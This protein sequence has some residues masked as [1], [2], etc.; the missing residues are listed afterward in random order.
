[1]NMKLK[2]LAILVFIMPLKSIAQLD[3][4]SLLGNLAENLPQAGMENDNDPNIG[5]KGIDQ[6]N[7]PREEIDFKDSEYGFT[8]GKTFNNQPKSKFKTEPLEYFGYDFFYEQPSTFAQFDNAPIPP[9][10]VIG[11]NDFIKIILFGNVNKKY[12][13]TVNRDGDIFVP[14]IGPLSVAGLSFDDLKVVI[15]QAIGTQLIGTQVNIT[16]GS[17]RAIDIFI[18]GSASNPGMFSI[19]ALSTITNAIIKSGGVDIAGSLRD[20]KIKRNGKIVK[21]VDFY[22][23][24]LNG[25][26][27]NDTRLMQ[28]D[29]IFIEPLGKTAAINGEVNRPGI[30]ELKSGETLDDLLRFAG[31]LKPK[32][33]LSD[34]DIM[35]IDSDQNSFNLISLNL[36]NQRPSSINIQNGDVISIYSVPDNLKSALLIQ[37]HSQQPGFYAW[38]QGMR[39]N[40]LFNSPED[41]LEMTDLNYVL[42]KRKESN[43]KSFNF[44]QV[45]LEEVFAD[46]DSSKNILLAD[47]DEIFL[48]PSM[49]TPETITTRMIQ[50]DYQLDQETN[51]MVMDDE[52]SS[53]TYLRKSLMEETIDLNNDQKS[54]NQFNNQNEDYNSLD[55]RRYYEYS[56]FDYC[57]LPEDMAIMVAEQSGFR[58]KKSIPIED[59]E[60]LNSPQD[61]IKFQQSLE[62]ERVK[63]KDNSEETIS[64]KLTEL[65][66]QQIL[67]PII[68][69][70]KR[71]DSNDSLNLVSVFGNVH[72]PGSYP[73]TDNMILSDVIKAAGGLKNGTYSSEVELSRRNNIGKKYSTSNTYTNLQQASRVKLEPMDTVNLKQLSSGLKTVEILG[74]VYFPGVYPISENQT[75]SEL[76]KRAGGLTEY[77]SP[78]SAYF[79]R[80]ELK[81]AEIERLQ[82]AQ[83]ELKRKVVLS[84][85]AGGLGQASLDSKS[86]NQLTGLLSQDSDEYQALGRLVIDLES[87]LE[88]QINDLALEDGDTITIP[89][90]KQSIS[91]IGEVFVSNSHI[92][93][94]NLRI[95][96]YLNLSGGVTPFADK[97]NIYLIKSDGSILSPSQLMSAGFFRANKS[98]LEPGDTI[99]VPLQLQPFSGIKATTEITQIIYQMALA[100]AAVNSF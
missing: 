52:W 43:S 26:I 48:I 66:R 99:V 87:I 6:E 10:Y 73:F 96:D 57:T 71:N 68:D 69:I 40:D 50:D 30:Y 46:P 91:V 88:N 19:S 32:A 79:Q 28:G 18:L 42:I 1:M 86:I 20:I 67:E 97:Q 13:L 93:E 77:A 92:F 22:D 90:F 3:E 94:E 53:L 78:K 29:V 41:L 14:E 34:A 35:R 5:N 80:Q 55:I 51:T 89:K 38:Q 16:L 61:F 74:E 33:N 39:V 44:L 76:I 62:L 70:I 56:I 11:P 47:R 25:D 7:S 24:L 21:E 23:L 100:A 64:T 75:L 95:E 49:L 15:N 82:K 59:L 85:Q 27:D 98:S 2:L 17:L 36:N 60:E 8:G 9:D 72:F 83:S 12:E 54:I 37:G 58:P 65:C 4:L 84:S 45:D 31:N 81:E 63:I